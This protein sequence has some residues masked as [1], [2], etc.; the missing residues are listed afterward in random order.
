MN[1]R[2]G[3]LI[4]K[5]QLRSEIDKI[6]QN[7]SYQKIIINNL[8]DEITTNKNYSPKTSK[9]ILS[10]NTNQQALKETLFTSKVNEE[11]IFNESNP[12]NIELSKLMGHKNFSTLMSTLKK[13]FGQISNDY[14][15]LQEQYVESEKA[16]NK[17][18]LELTEKDRKIESLNEKNISKEQEVKEY[19][20][21][22]KYL[23]S[24]LQDYSEQLYNQSIII[25]RRNRDT[26]RRK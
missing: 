14:K 7:A 24:K 26:K 3:N 2:K 17:Y 11:S 10:A 18:R 5:A 1:I 20:N 23:E 9:S 19:K 15:T 6:K 13:R 12:R 25:R 4:R 22:I 16:N 21:K 8:C